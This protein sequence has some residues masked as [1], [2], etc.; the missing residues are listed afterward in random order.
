[1]PLEDLVVRY[2][3]HRTSEKKHKLTLAINRDLIEW[4]KK[5]D[6]NLSMTLEKVL[7]SLRGEKKKT[8]KHD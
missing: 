6:I 8:L 5:E 1:M 3:K 4:A 7:R 2:G